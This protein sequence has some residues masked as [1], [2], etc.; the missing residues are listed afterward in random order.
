MKSNNET[1]IKKKW[2]TIKDECMMGETPAKKETDT[3]NGESPQI[4]KNE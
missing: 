3:Y 1:E 4:E 2:I